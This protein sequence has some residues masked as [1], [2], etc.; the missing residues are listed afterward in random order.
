MIEL[1]T[2]D[3]ARRFDGSLESMYRLRYHI[4]IER[5]NWAVPCAG[6]LEK[7]QFDHPG[8]IY[9]FLR[10]RDGDVV[11]SCRFLPTTGPNLLNDVFPYLV[12]GPL[13]NSPVI[14]EASRLAIDHRKERLE[15]VGGGRRVAG[16]LFCGIQEF[17][18]ALNLDYLVSVSDLR[19]ERLLKL[20]GWKLTRLG[21]P[22]PVGSI[23]AVAEITEIS[24][25]V[26]QTLRRK[27]GIAEPV[28]AVADVLTGGRAA[29]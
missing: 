7:D 8:T 27:N 19:L 26:L 6:S 29:A 23:Q 16:E 20:A 21:K 3:T 17:A 13:P 18:L 11:A 22:H 1:M 24:R 28:L 2:H 14:W 15:S 4:F 5:L 25:E 9:L 10:N 12:D